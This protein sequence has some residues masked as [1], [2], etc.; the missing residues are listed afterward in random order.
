MFLSHASCILKLQEGLLLTA[1]RHN[2]PIEDLCIVAHSR[3][4]LILSYSAYSM[5]SSTTI[6]GDIVDKAIVYTRDRPSW[7]VLLLF[8]NGT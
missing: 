8:L 3:R 7:V 2:L 5:V 6:I 1:K 4:L